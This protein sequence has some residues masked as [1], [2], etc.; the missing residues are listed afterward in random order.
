[1]DILNHTPPD[2][3]RPQPMTQALA[4]AIE[5]GGAMLRDREFFAL[6]RM[7]AEDMA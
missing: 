2:P 7:L 6:E 5:A 1:M 4:E 3:A